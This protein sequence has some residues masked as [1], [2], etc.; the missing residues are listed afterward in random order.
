[1]NIS[2]M[3]ILNINVRSVTMNLL[4]SISILATINYLTHR[5]MNNLLFQMNSGVDYLL[6]EL[7][8][9]DVENSISV[10]EISGVVGI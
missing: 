10:G 3:D 9:D 5:Q 8:H 7:L 6:C 1:M 2:R 4:L